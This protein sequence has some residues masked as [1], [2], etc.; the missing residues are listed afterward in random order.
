MRRHAACGDEDCRRIPAGGDLEP[1]AMGIAVQ[2]LQRLG[3][4]ARCSCPP[5]GP[6]CDSDAR[7]AGGLDDARRE[8]GVVAEEQHESFARRHVNDCTRRLKGRGEIRAAVIYWRRVGQLTQRIGAERG[9]SHRH[10]KAVGGLQHEC[11]HQGAIW[12]PGREHG[13]VLRPYDSAIPDAHWPRSHPR[14]Q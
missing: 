1:V 12:L 10:L 2:R 14:E 7:T 5:A 13:P 3:T 4:L 11:R 9:R 8:R 6:L